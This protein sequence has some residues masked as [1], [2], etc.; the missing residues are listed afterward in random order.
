[1]TVL[2]KVWCL[3]CSSHPVDGVIRRVFV[4]N[5]DYV[6]T[7]VNAPIP[8]ICACCGRQHD[9]TPGKPEDGRETVWAYEYTEESS[10]A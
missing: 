10:N 2:A 3:I 9:E 7:A 5:G 1:M 8:R 4:D 6:V